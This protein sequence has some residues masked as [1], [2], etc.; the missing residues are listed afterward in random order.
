[1]PSAVLVACRSRRSW[2][3]R[4]AVLPVEHATH[5]PLGRSA[6]WAWMGGFLGRDDLIV[7]SGACWARAAPPSASAAAL[8]SVLVDLGADQLA[9]LLRPCSPAWSCAASSPSAACCRP[10][11]NWLGGAVTRDQGR[12]RTPR[13]P[14]DLAGHDGDRTSAYRLLPG[15]ADL[16][17]APELGCGPDVACRAVAD[18]DRSPAAT[19]TCSAEY[20]ASP[21]GPWRRLKSASRRALAI[22]EEVDAAS[23]GARYQRPSNVSCGTG[24]A[25]TWPDHADRPPAAPTVWNDVTWLA[26]SANSAPTALDD[27]LG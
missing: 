18:A 4:H 27:D 11:A 20:P 1:M 12:P 13:P 25:A 22:L 26:T 3:P 21:P 14:P 7:P 9:H 5:S 6:P 16:R 24:S 23:C 2:L 15:S 17:P 8:L 10:V 19:A